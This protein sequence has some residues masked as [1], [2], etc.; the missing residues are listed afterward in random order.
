MVYTKSLIFF[1]LLLFIF[2]ILV[3]LVSLNDIV[4]PEYKENQIKATTIPSPSGIFGYSTYIWSLFSYGLGI[5][6]LIIN[7][8]LTFP[9]LFIVV[10]DY[11]V[12]IIRGN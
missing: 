7:G 10:V 6:P 2:N 9:I 12:P 11:V 3:G 5:T 8:L 4:N 1:I